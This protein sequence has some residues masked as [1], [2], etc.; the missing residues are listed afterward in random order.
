MGQTLEHCYCVLCLCVWSLTLVA[1]A[2]LAKVVRLA[3]VTYTLTCD[4]NHRGLTLLD[5][6]AMHKNLPGSAQKVRTL[7]LCHK[8]LFGAL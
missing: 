2:C 1:S 3:E 5:V 7:P 4:F 6:K 8:V